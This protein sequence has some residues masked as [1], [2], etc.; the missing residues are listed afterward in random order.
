MT[1]RTTARDVA[2]LAGVSQTAVSLVVNGNDVGNIAAATRERILRA[3]DE[4]GYRPDRIARSMRGKATATLGVITDQI[5]TSPFAGAII[6]GAM[7]RAW[8]DQH[9]LMV[10]DT[11]I[12]DAEPPDRGERE[13]AAVAELI[14]RRVD[15]ILYATMG[16]RRVTPLVGLRD[17]PS[18]FVNCLADGA[19]TLTIVPDDE[20]GGAAAV[21]ALLSAGHRDIALFLGPEDHPATAARLL[22]ARAELAAA[23]LQVPDDRLYFVGS[24]IDEGIAIADR[25]IGGPRPPTGVMCFNDRVALGVIL[26]AGRLGV[27]VPED[28]SVVGYD[29]QEHLAAVIRPALTTVAL[30]HYEMGRLAAEE[31]I[32]ALIGDRP[33][34]PEVHRLR[35]PLV[36]RDS[37]SAPAR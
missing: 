33:L 28:L 13:A 10:I 18:V 23:G 37:V 36:E 17:T 16:L 24:D 25:V 15:G 12:G 1:Q 21:R 31:L 9:M 32:A 34:Q 14:D 29:D 3:A 26:A 19:E 30:P 2:A 35:C 27:R 20:A 8:Q 5:A 22:G 7:D 11:G 4:L 6:R